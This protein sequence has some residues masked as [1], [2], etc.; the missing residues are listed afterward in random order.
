[1]S[2]LIIPSA[3]EGK[4]E[5]VPTGIFKPISTGDLKPVT[6]VVTFVVAILA[7]CYCS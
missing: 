5:L 3:P 4:L 7:K 1:V 2:F 6:G